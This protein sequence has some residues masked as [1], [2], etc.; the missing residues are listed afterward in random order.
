ITNVT[1]AA[2]GN[3]VLLVGGAAVT[4]MHLSASG[5]NPAVN[6]LGFA[7]SQDAVLEL[8]APQDAVTS[9]QLSADASFQV[10][11]NGGAGQAV[12]VTKAATAT[13]TGVSGL[14]SSINAA[15][16]AAG[17]GTKLQAEA[18]GNRIVLKAIDAT[19]TSFHLSATAATTAVTEIGFGT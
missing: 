1:A 14:A 19:V 6:D 17:L 4:A 12:A 16:T 10:A 7:L 5:G 13:N 11:I 9:G 15:L 18:I 3:R 8:V 2:L